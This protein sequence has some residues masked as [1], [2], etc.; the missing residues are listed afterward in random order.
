MRGAVKEAMKEAMKGTNTVQLAQQA[1]HELA[2]AGDDALI[3]LP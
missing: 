2:A 1:A 3:D